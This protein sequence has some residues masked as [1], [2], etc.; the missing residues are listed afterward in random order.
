MG[1]AAPT[2]HRE[3]FQTSRLLEYFSEKELVLQTG[4][5]PDRWPEVILKELLDNSLDACEDADT[6]PEIMVTIAPDQIVVDDNG[7][8]LPSPVILR[9]LDFSVR[10]SS[11][12]AY[13]S[14]SRGAQDNALKTILAI[15]FVRGGGAAEHPHP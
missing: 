4:H 2:L 14:P 13:I 1:R 10:V 12:D 6:V 15:P 3:T 7:P 11:K 8:G 9:I 5:A